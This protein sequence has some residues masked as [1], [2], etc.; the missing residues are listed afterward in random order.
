MQLK[1]GISSWQQRMEWSN[2]KSQKYYLGVL[3][4]NTSVQ[5]V[6]KC[7]NHKELQIM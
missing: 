2:E 4:M 3:T 7:T 5:I 6:E 1:E